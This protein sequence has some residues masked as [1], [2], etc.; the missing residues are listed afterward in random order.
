MKRK[1]EEIDSWQERRTLEKIIKR[2]LR[3]TLETKIFSKFT[4]FTKCF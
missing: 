3:R 1:T 4:P 2:H